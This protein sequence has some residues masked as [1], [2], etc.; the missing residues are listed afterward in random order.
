MR[1]IDRP[2]VHWLVGAIGL[3][4][5]MANPTAGHAADQLEIQWEVANR[6]RF[7]AE[8]KDFNLH[9]AAA[10]AA[11]GGWKTIL[12]TERSLIQETESKGWSSRLGRLCFNPSTGLPP[13]SCNRDGTVENYLNPQ[14][15]RILLLAKTPADFATARC[16]WT[17]GSGANAKT[18]E[19]PC[20]AI[21]DDQRVSIRRATPVRLVARN[22]AG[23]TLQADISIQTRDILIV[24]IGDSATSGEGNPDRPVALSEQGFCFRRLGMIQDERFYLP[25]RAGVHVIADCP[26]PGEHP[27]ERDQ[28]DKRSAGWLYSACH[29][30]LYSHQMRTALALAIETPQVSVTY[31]P[32]GCTGATIREGLLDVQEARERPKRG[33]KPG[34]R[35]V[36]GQFDQLASAFGVTPKKPPFRPID[37]ILLTI[38]ANDIGFS[39]LVANVLVNTD[40]ERGVLS[41]A[42]MITTPQR[43]DGILRSTLKSDFRTLRAKLRIYAGGNLERVIFTT[44]GNPGTY[45]GGHACPAGRRGFDA[46]PAFSVDGTKLR[47][48][49]DFV[50]GTFLPI[51]QEYVQCSPDAGCDDPAKDRMTFVDQHKTAFA[52]HGF[53]ASDASDPDFDRQC[54]HDGDSFN[55]SATGLSK[56][57]ACMGFVATDF[58]AYASRAR[59]IRTANDSYFAAMTYPARSPFTDPSDIH[60]GLWGLT[61]VVYGGAMHP[62]AEGHAALAEGTLAAAKQ[63]LQIAPAPGVVAA[64]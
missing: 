10:R 3:A 61:S 6:F 48:T 51:L 35:Y 62:T 45:N 24:G 56:P 37:L 21:I 40:P 17:I 5:S 26:F 28:W 30:S 53:C 4:L 54:F 34:P 57:L 9:L 36:E 16:T 7:F 22:D 63:I 55:G 13:Q 31:L 52:Q 19:K 59:W 50:S 14:S 46:H 42:Q 60:D 38:G 1:R 11:G 8:Q 41:L 2:A 25:G 27:H 15:N 47:D 20:T 12:E 32:L 39:G 18:I 29:R 64:R 23:Q 44:Y 49:V 58:R 33:N 43:A